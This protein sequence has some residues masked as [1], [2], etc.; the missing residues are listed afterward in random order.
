MTLPKR[1]YQVKHGVLLYLKFEN[2][3]LF[4]NC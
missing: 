3:E 4:V 1:L 2:L